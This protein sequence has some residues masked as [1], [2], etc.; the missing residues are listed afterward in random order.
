MVYLILS[1]IHCNWKFRRACRRAVSKRAFRSVNPCVFYAAVE[2]WK[3]KILRPSKKFLPYSCYMDKLYI[4]VI[5][6]FF[7]FSAYLIT[8]HGDLVKVMNNFHMLHKKIEYICIYIYVCIIIRTRKRIRLL[9]DRRRM[10][11]VWSCFK[12]IE[13]L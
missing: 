1:S 6:S 10:Q 5:A 3:N 2:T 12:E 11:R 9:G 4:K 13:D 7:F 8:Y